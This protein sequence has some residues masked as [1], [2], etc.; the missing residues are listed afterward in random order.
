[1]ADS[2]YEDIFG[3]QDLTEE[4]IEKKETMNSFFDILKIRMEEYRE[5]KEEQ[6]NQRAV[7]TFQNIS[8]MNNSNFLAHNT[9]FDNNVKIDNTKYQL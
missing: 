8:M 3:K 1:M 7:D 9:P 2:K 6:K 5:I 4:K